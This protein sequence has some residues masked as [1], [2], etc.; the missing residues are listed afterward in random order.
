MRY[1]IIA[2][3]AS[4]DLHG[5]NLIKALK[6]EDP[7]AEFYCFGGDLMESEGG[8]LLKHYRDMA[9]MGAIDVVRNIGKIGKNFQLGREKLLE[10]KPDVLILID[11]PG[12]NLKMAAF[13]HDGLLLASIP[14][15]M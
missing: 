10:V 9:F 15:G 3:E 8:I 14:A 12:F 13:A 4:G 5:S 6:A 2:G 1:F 7:R 11:Y